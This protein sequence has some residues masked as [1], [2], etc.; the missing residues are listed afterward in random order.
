MG[1]FEPLRH[2]AEVHLLL[3]PAPR[4]SGLTFATACP[5]DELD[6]NWQRLI[7][8]HLAEKQHRGVLIGAPITDLRITLMSGKAHLKHTEGG[9]FRQAT[10][11]AVRQGLMSAE[12][13]LLEPWYRVELDLPEENLGRAMADLQRMGG[14]FAPPRNDGRRAALTAE[15][16]AAAL[17]DYADEVRAY[18]RGQGQFS[19]LPLGYRPCQNPQAVIEASGYDPERD[20]ENPA[21]SVFCGHGAG[22]HVPWNEVPLHM[23]LPSILAPKE[24]A[25][26]AAPVRRT[27]TPYTGTLEQDAELQRIFERTYGPVRRPAFAAPLRAAPQKASAPAEAVTEYLLVDGYN[28]IFAWPELKKLAAQ[29]LDAAR[30][31]LTDLLCNYRG[32][33]PCEVILVFD[34]YKVPGGRGEVSRYHNITVVY[35]KEAETADMYIEKATYK[36]EKARKVRVAT[37]DGAEQLIIL[38]HG[39][40][41][42]SARAFR[43]EIELANRRIADLIAENNL[44]SESAFP[45]SGKKG[46]Q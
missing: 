41:R 36:L 10:Y 28:L 40:L 13:V 42:V 29:N 46:S 2:Y 24:E 45:S 8:T 26:P 31:A 16:P 15:V 43:E 12:S 21:G 35:T 5:E 17:G 34:A 25:G 4:G 37:S 11:R 7:L 3:E 44:K 32:F 9:D 6:K 38:G 20:T 23:H 33:H 30:Q 14:S 22:Y 18:T 1:H 39:A 27:G 19:A